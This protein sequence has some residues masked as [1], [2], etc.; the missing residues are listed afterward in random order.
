MSNNNMSEMDESLSST[1]S[2]SSILPG[3]SIKHSHIKS[4]TKFKVSLN[5]HS[6]DHINKHVDDE[7]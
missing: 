6:T 3:V 7:V 4:M 1:M 2:R 5:L